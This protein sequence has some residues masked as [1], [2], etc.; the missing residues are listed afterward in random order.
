MLNFFHRNNIRVFLVQFLLTPLLDVRLVEVVHEIRLFLFI[1]RIGYLRLWQHCP[2]VL[3]NLLV[4]QQIVVSLAV[5]PVFVDRVGVGG[6]HHCVVSIPRQH[7]IGIAR[8][9]VLGCAIPTTEMLSK[10]VMRIHFVVRNYRRDIHIVKWKV[11][12]REYPYG[13]R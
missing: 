1:I 12:R 8:R 4:M 5:K 13:A 7:L 10:S 9:W 6:P 3:A 11:K 2:S